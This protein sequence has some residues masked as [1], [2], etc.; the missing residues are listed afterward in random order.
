MTTYLDQ[1]FADFDESAAHADLSEARNRLEQADATIAAATKERDDARGDIQA[2]EGMIAAYRRHTGA[3]VAQQGRLIENGAAS[4]GGAPKRGRAAIRE[5]VTE[6][7]DQDWTTR[8]VA[9]ALGL[10]KDAEHGIQVALSRM[11]RDGELARPR[12]GVYRLPSVT[13]AGEEQRDRG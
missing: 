6:S 13:S 9:E 4:N 12:T 5:L 2:L 10:G 3:P 7:P 11:F 1:L 8:R